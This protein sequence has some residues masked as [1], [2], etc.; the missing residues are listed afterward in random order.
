MTSNECEAADEL[1]K[2]YLKGEDE[3]FRKLTTRAIVTSIYPVSVLKFLYKIRLCV[4]SDKFQFQRWRRK[5]TK[6]KEGRRRKS[7]RLES[8][9]FDWFLVFKIENSILN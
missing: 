8:C 2:A 1:I 7:I 4:N 5:E 6:R 3:K 9:C